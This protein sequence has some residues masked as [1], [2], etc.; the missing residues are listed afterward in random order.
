V[1]LLAARVVLR[2]R[3]LGDVL[4]LTVPFCLA[5]RRLLGR[6]GLTSLL[7][8]FALCLYVQRGRHWNWYQTWALAIILGD[9]LEG[10]FTV[11]F[12][13]LLFQPSEAVRPAAVWGRFARRLFHYLA[14]LFVARLLIT[15]SIATIIGAAATP[16]LAVHLLFVR[17][18]CLLEGAG[19]FGAIGRASKFVHRQVSSGLGV[20]LAVLA[21]PAVMAVAAELLGDAIV[22]TLLQLGSP[23]GELF[24]QGGSAYAL[25][26]FFLSVP[27]VAAARFLKYI[28]V[29][30]RKEGWDIQLRF[31]AIASAERAEERG[32]DRADDRT[33]PAGSSAA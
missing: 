5:G 23:F 9:L 31:T 6:L 28:D 17:E 22:S 27:V 8:A 32:D 16:F 4:D 3:S 20:L 14:S 21:A 10:L 15:V 11:A 13:D 12:G 1:N 33:H 2:P 29:R 19:V 25:L 7:P 30:T 26:G 24:K 18:V